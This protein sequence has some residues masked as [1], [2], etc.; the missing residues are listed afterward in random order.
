MRGKNQFHDADL[1]D[2]RMR[3]LQ[4][5]GA[6]SI[7]FKHL[8]TSEN[9]PHLERLRSLLRGSKGE[10]FRYSSQAFKVQLEEALNYVDASP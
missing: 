9:R 7:S 5:C 3:R 2:K 4:I 6:T 10:R 8:K 1:D